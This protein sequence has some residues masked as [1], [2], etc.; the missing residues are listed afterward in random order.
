MLL[1]LCCFTAQLSQAASPFAVKFWSGGPGRNSYDTGLLKAAL[2]ATRT[3][4]GNYSF[5]VVNRSLGTNRG[6]RLL[7]EGELI[8]I[9]AAPIR[10]PHIARLEHIIP[11]DFPILEGLLGYRKLIIPSDK[12][13]NFAEIK[14]LSDLAKFR[15]GQGRAWLDVDILKYNN[16]PVVDSGVYEQLFDMLKRDRFDYILLGAHEI[17]EALDYAHDVHPDFIILPDLLIYY[18]FPVVYHVSKNYPELAARI[19]IGLKKVKASGQMADLFTRHFSETV[20]A[21][22][23]TRTLLTITNPYVEQHSPISKPVLMKQ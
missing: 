9:Y 1:L 20:Q 3:T 21:L 15:A 14:S 23:N 19:L 4:H 11:V 2:D 7:A 16:L 10:P 6:R 13:H 18:P 8:N 12:K 17:D 5:A 22:Q